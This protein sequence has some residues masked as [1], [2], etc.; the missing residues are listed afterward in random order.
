MAEMFEKR[1]VIFFIRI[2]TTFTALTVSK[3]IFAYTLMC[4][5]YDSREQIIKYDF[6]WIYHLGYH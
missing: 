2:I 5:E 3:S 4:F 6:S 1:G